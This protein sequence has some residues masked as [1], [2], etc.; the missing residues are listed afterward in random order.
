MIFQRDTKSLF[1]L[2]IQRS[3]L[4]EDIKKYY[5]VQL[6]GWSCCFVQRNKILIIK[7]DC[8]RDRNY[9]VPTQIGN[10]FNWSPSTEIVQCSYIHSAEIVEEQFFFIYINFFSPLKLSVYMR[11]M[12]NEGF[13]LDLLTV[14]RKTEP[15]SEERERERRFSE[16]LHSFRSTKM[17]V[18]WLEGN[19]CM[20]KIDQL[21]RTFFSSSP[22]F[23]FLPDDMQVREREWKKDARE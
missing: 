15:I 16:F 12:T 14:V 10:T 11:R 17:W 5:Y 13:L 7:N 21:E 9:S 23:S 19:F 22:Q 6:F 20:E 4:V 8:S 18:W 3:Y 1:L 2:A